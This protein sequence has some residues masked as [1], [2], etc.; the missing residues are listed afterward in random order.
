MAYSAT[1]VRKTVFG[2]ERVVIFD[3]TADAQSGV[4]DCG[5]YVDG[6]TVGPISMATLSL[7]KFRPNINA[8]SAASNNN[9]MISGAAS[10][11]RFYLTVF[12]H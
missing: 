12:G 7:V 3:V 5:M 4:V 8:A 6:F 10:G 1:V 9:I 2:N 11:D